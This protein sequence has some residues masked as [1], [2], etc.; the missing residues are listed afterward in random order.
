MR[1]SHQ[2][3]Y[4]HTRRF[5]DGIPRHTYAQIH[6]ILSEV[7]FYTNC[8]CFNRPSVLYGSTSRYV[9]PGLISR[10]VHTAQY[11]TGIV[12]FKA[13]INLSNEGGGD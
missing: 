13:G 2:M 11:K 5:T 6:F 8:G 1:E 7:V 12:L 4:K 10:T 3:A 9:S